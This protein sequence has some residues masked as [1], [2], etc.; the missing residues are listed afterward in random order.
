MQRFF[1]IYA[2]FRF[3]NQTKLSIGSF[4]TD[5]VSQ[6][7]RLLN[8][9]GSEICLQKQDCHPILVG[10]QPA[11]VNEDLTTSGVKFLVLPQ[12]SLKT[13]ILLRT[14]RD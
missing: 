4:L 14:D 11:T 10:L 6:G 7:L 13:L 8:E 12:T 5:L 1:S 2:I 9:N 3:K